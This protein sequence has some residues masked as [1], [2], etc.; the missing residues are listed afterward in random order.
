MQTPIIS[1]SQT[2]SIFPNGQ[3]NTTPWI[4]ELQMEENTLYKGG[5]SCPTM[6][7]ECLMNKYVRIALAPLGKEAQEVW[8]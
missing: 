4:G 1:V 7:V 8:K 2:I 3:A 6:F 5:I